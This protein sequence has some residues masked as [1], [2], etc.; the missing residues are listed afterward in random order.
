[1]YSLARSSPVGDG[2]GEL[3]TSQRNLY[4]IGQTS[5]I[6]TMYCVCSKYPII[7]NNT[8]IPYHQESMLIN[9]F[10]RKLK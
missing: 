10:I 1:M 7:P 3:E 9:S 5:Q 6:V 4:G 2:G 8:G